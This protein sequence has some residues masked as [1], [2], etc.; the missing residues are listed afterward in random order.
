MVWMTRCSLSGISLTRSGNTAEVPET[1]EQICEAFYLPFLSA[2]HTQPN[3]TSEVAFQ[4]D[5]AYYKL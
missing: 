2:A 3:N 4:E 5:G 1:S